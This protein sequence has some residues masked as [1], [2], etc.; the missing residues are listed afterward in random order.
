M[1]KTLLGI[2]LLGFLFIGFMLFNQT[3]E[4]KEADAATAYAVVFQKIREESNQGQ[5]GFDSYRERDPRDPRT[6]SWLSGLSGQMR[7]TYFHLQAEADEYR[8]KFGKDYAGYE[9]IN[10]NL[11]RLRDQIDQELRLSIT[12]KPETPTKEMGSLAI[13]GK[14]DHPKEI[15]TGDVYH[16]TN[17]YHQQGQDH[18]HSESYR[19]GDN[20]QVDRRI[21][22]RVYAPVQGSTYEDYSVGP[23]SLSQIDSRSHIDSRRDNR[24]WSTGAQTLTEGA[25]VSIGGSKFAVTGNTQTS[26]V[27][28]PRGYLSFDNT[29]RLLPTPGGDP[30]KKPDFGAFTAP[31]LNPFDPPAPPPGDS[32]P[33]TTLTREGTAHV[34]HI[35][36]DGVANRDTTGTNAL[37]A[38]PAK[39]DSP[40][41]IPAAK[42]SAPPGNPTVPDPP[43][44]IPK[45]AAQPSGFGSIDIPAHQVSAPVQD[46]H[47]GDL[48]RGSSVKTSALELQA[49]AEHQEETE[50][51]EK[52]LKKRTIS[53]ADLMPMQALPRPEVVLKKSK[54]TETR[55]NSQLST[56]DA[57]ANI[58]QDT[59]APPA[60]KHKPASSMSTVIKPSSTQIRRGRRGTRA[61][62]GPAAREPRLDT[63]E[64]DLKSKARLVNQIATNISKTQNPSKDQIHDFYQKFTDLAQTVPEVIVVRPPEADQPPITLK[65]QSKKFF[66]KVMNEIDDELEIPQTFDDKTINTIVDLLT[67]YK[68]DLRGVKTASPDYTVW[69]TNMDTVER[70][71]KYVVDR[72]PMT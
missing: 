33:A 68:T 34:P 8:S 39:V 5:R 14:P 15:R 65:P 37:L 64:R 25:K 32:K 1:D 59:N 56:R 27:N 22:S 48:E 63:Y 9:D 49:I 67:H 21:D 55:T 35:A 46:V 11:N 69:K 29:K 54:T 20:T 26:T 24:D 60:K 52:N 3:S 38:A 45:P 44:V 50:M 61:S 47:A 62:V 43:P 40:P 36:L 23:Q 72:F 42:P 19:G 7:E 6:R 41:Q 66:V 30:A 2:M 71:R 16:T 12:A 17:I 13:G 53:D 10:I 70:A 4:N 58:N 28:E 18:S 31:I 51:T 57:G